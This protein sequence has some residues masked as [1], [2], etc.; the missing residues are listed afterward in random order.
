MYSNEESSKMVGNLSVSDKKRINRFMEN[1]GIE[2]PEI[3]REDYGLDEAYNLEANI[4]PQGSYRQSYQSDVV[5]GNDIDVKIVYKLKY[6]NETIE[7]LKTPA[8][9]QSV[10]ATDIYSAEAILSENV[11]LN[12]SPRELE[13]VGD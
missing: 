7:K 10:P 3:I 12:E 5:K 1:L 4:W 6:N 2:K 11:E 13:A 9:A 8:L